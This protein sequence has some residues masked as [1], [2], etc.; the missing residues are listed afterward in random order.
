[1]PSP[2][3]RSKS[4]PG[5][6]E[7]DQVPTAPPAQITT[8]ALSGLSHRHALRTAHATNT[9]CRP[10]ANL[11]ESNNYS[12]TPI[13]QHY[14]PPS[15]SLEYL[16]MEATSCRSSHPA[17]ETLVSVW[18]FF[19]DRK[20]PNGLFPPYQFGISGAEGVLSIYRSYKA[21]DLAE[22]K[23]D[24]SDVMFGVWKGY[25]SFSSPSSS[26]EGRGER[27]GRKW[28]E[29]ERVREGNSSAA[30]AKLRF[31]AI[32]EVNNAQVKIMAAYAFAKK[33]LDREQDILVVSREDRQ[34]EDEG[35][36]WTLFDAFLGTPSVKAI[37]RMAVDHRDELGY[38]ELSKLYVKYSSF[39]YPDEGQVLLPTLLVEMRRAKAL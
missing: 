6:K 24:W 31:V 18:N 9:P 37:Q 23:I 25:S 15:P 19:A 4:K 11:T 10:T 3:P 34:V 33:R 29:K 36:G 26:K 32:S 1:M 38:I 2:I 28:R 39:E 16:F 27:T 21:E 22:R 7:A 5:S 30:I 14:T 12:L 13:F 35:G 8:I 20:D 17:I